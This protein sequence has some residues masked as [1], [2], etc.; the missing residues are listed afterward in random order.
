LSLATRKNTC[1][2]TFNYIKNSNSVSQYPNL[3]NFA[4][5]ISFLR[6][7]DDRLDIRVPFRRFFKAYFHFRLT[8]PLSNYCQMLFYPVPEALPYHWRFLPYYVVTFAASRASCIFQV[9][10]S[11]LNLTQTL[12]KDKYNERKTMK[13]CPLPATQG[14]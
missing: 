9:C 6:E 8:N 14:Y 4:A 5:G 10:G 2:G 3:C 13:S 7:K 12:T 1:K 11:L